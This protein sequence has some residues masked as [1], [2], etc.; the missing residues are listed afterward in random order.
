MTEIN[1]ITEYVE[2]VIRSKLPDASKYPARTVEAM[3]YAMSAGGKR[4]RPTLML[5]TFKAMNGSPAME[6]AVKAFMAAMEMIHTHS[7]IHDD[8]PAL[9]NDSLRRGRPTVHVKYDEAVAIL[10]GDALLNF[11]YETVSS[12]YSVDM[13]SVN[14]SEQLYMLRL[15]VKALGELSRLTGI[16]GMLGG[17]CLDVEKT[18][19]RLSDSERDYIYTNKT[20]ALIAASIAIG[21]ILAGASDTAVSNLREAG[22]RIGNAFQVQDDILDETS[23]VETLGKE[24]HQDVRNSKNTYVTAF[25]IDKARVYVEQETDRAVKLINA[26]LDSCKAM[27][28]SVDIIPDANIDIESDTAGVL[29]TELVRKMATRNK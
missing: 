20:G 11:A 10:A 14:D 25:G 2:G 4:I 19:I 9:D 28:K 17:Q 27:N 29:L 16:D 26:E 6:E 15:T 12:L 1:E 21:A 7:L 18:G 5:L 23:D 3:N 13:N 24:V 22:Y 8:L